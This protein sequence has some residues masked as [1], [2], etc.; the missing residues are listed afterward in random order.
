M[1]YVDIQRIYKTGSKLLNRWFLN[2][3]LTGFIP[4][5][6]DSYFIVKMCSNYHIEIAIW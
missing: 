2:L 1:F 5:R 3:I 6:V 4:A